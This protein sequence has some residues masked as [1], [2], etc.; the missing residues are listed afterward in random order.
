MK[1]IQKQVN[2]AL[3]LLIASLVLLLSC[4]G[5]TRTDEILNGGYLPTPV[6]YSAQAVS[7]TRL[8]VTFGNP[9]LMVASV[10]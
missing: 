10:I 7:A 6:I 5:G 9:W 2:K 8:K 3:I 1:I 4:Y